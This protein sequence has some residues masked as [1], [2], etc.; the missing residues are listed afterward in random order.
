MTRR[1]I[2]V[3][4]HSGEDREVEDRPFLEGAAREAARSVSIDLESGDRLG[5]DLAE[6]L[7]APTHVIHA[8]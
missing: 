6:L 8:S 4:K 1:R 3:R 5:V 7:D 2:T